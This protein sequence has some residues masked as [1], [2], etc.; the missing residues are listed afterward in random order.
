MQVGSQ[1]D[2]V[3]DVCKPVMCSLLE[4][5]SVIEGEKSVQVGQVRL[6]PSQFNSVDPVGRG[7]RFD[8]DDVCHCGQDLKNLR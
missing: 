3:W 6:P 7:D 5:S 8:W 2:K 4:S 1:N